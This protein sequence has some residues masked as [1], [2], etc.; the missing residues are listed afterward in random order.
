MLSQLSPLPSTRSAKETGKWRNRGRSRLTEPIQCY[1]WQCLRHCSLDAKA[2]QFWIP[3]SFDLVPIGRFWEPPSKKEKCF[4][5]QLLLLRCPW[6]NE[7]HLLSDAPEELLKSQDQKVLLLSYLVWLCECSA[8]LEKNRHGWMK[9]YRVPIPICALSLWV[10][11]N[12]QRH[13]SR[14]PTNQESHFFY[15]SIVL[16]TKVRN[17]QPGSQS[18]DHLISCL[19]ADACVASLSFHLESVSLL[20]ACW[21]SSQLTLSQVSQIGSVSSCLRQSSASWKEAGG[22]GGGWM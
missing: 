10:F 12:T 18:L 16:D 22:G 17:C 2:F 9:G 5:S 15:P 6:T 7:Q 20:S 13:S 14:A 19:R 21:L 1:F 3:A 11:A 4:F 8:G